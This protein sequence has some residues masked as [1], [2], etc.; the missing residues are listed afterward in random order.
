GGMEPGFDPTAL[1]QANGDHRF[2]L[3]GRLNQAR[4]VKEHPSWTAQMDAT[5]R[6]IADEY[7]RDFQPENPVTPAT[8]GFMWNDFSVAPGEPALGYDSGRAFIYGQA[9]TRYLLATASSDAQRLRAVFR[10]HQ[11]SSVPNPMMRR[12]KASNGLFRHWQERDSVQL[13]SA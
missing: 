2:Q 7:L 6:R 4:F 5:S 1:L 12:L 13:L 8:L 11:H 10:A 9:S 3:L